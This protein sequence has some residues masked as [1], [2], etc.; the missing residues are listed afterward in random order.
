MPAAKYSVSSF[1]CYSKR[2]CVIFVGFSLRTSDSDFERL[3]AR[4]SSVFELIWHGLAGSGNFAAFVGD[5]VENC[6]LF[7]VGAPD[8]RGL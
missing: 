8:A 5:A 3:K 6:T 1:F 4:Y 2:D 7:G